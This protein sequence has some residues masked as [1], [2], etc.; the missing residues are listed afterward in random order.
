MR[1]SE[2]D[3]SQIIPPFNF[4]RNTPNS[5]SSSNTCTLTTVSTAAGA[6]FG[7]RLSDVH[8]LFISAEELVIL[9]PTP[10]FFARIWAQHR[11]RIVQASPCSVSSSGF[12]PN[13]VY[14]PSCGVIIDVTVR[15]NKSSPLVHLNSIVAY[16]GY[17]SWMLMLCIPNFLLF[18]R[19]G[20]S[21]RTGSS[22][23]SLPQREKETIALHPLHHFL[24]AVVLLLR[25]GG[26]SPSDTDMALNRAQMLVRDSEAL[27]Q[28]RADHRIP[29]DVV[30]ECP[31]PNDD[32]DLVEGEGNRMPIRTWFIYQAGLR[33]PLN[34]LLR[35]V[36]STCGLTFMQV[37]V[38]FVR[39]MLAVEALMQREGLE[40][41]T[42]DLFHVYCVVK[43]RKNP[44]T[45]MLEGNH[46]LRL[47]KPNQPQ[48]RLVTDSPDKGQYLSDFIWVSGQWEF[49]VNEPD[50]FLVPRHRGYVSVGFNRRLG[51]RRDRCSAAISAVNNCGRSRKVSDLLG[52]I[53]LYRESSSSSWEIDLGNEALNEEVEVEDGEEVDQIPAAAPLVPAPLILVPE[54][55]NLPSSDSN[56]AI[57][58]PREI[59]EHSYSHSDSS[60]AGSQL[61]A[62]I[63]APKVRIL[64]KKQAPT[65]ETPTL[66]EAPISSTPAPAEDQSTVPSLMGGKRKGKQ[67]VEETSR[68]KRG[69]GNAVMLPQDVADHAAETT[70]EFGGKL[71]MLGAQRAVSSSLR[72]KQGMVDLKKA[73]QRAHSLENLLKQTQSELADARSAAEIAILHGMARLFE[74]ASDPTRSS[75]GSLLPLQSTPLLNSGAILAPINYCPTLKRENIGSLP[76]LALARAEC[77]TVVV[78]AHA[79]MSRRLLIGTEAWGGRGRPSFEAEGE[80]LV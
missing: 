22:S 75:R 59:V 60:S 12:P 46:Y 20:R 35:S 31:G 70:A 65:I 62:E 49:P 69:K 6:V 8:P 18:Y 71:V 15:I 28:F 44:D 50:L 77:Y 10:D 3:T 38:N 68:P 13:S 64:G 76:A 67:P 79:G 2:A 72:L 53:P 63:M 48:T 24:A 21:Q 42:E 45:Q 23:V 29:D 57:V 74:G 1:K 39:T 9:P 36:L 54:P 32:A 47:R 34:K 11:S 73:N 30:I 40:F 41:T 14:Q 26:A 55:I 5:T 7:K 78:E 43:P 17:A 37:S 4:S 25:V 19:A 80:N 66:P 51:K 27:A 52:Y 56:I 58:E 33:F 61:N 16:R